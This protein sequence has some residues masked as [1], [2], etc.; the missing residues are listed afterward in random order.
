MVK[1]LP[2][3]AGGERDVDLIL[4][5]GRFPRGG[6]GNPHQYSSGKSHGQ[7]S[8]AGYSPWGHKELDTTEQPSA[9]PLWRTGWRFLNKLKIELPYDPA[10]PLLD[11]HLEKN[12]IRKDT[13]TSVF[14]E[15]RSYNNQD[16]EEPKCP[17]TDRWIKKM[18]EIYTME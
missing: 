14:T 8:L 4:G 11:I 17:P 2:A 9:Q 18:W 12:M 10:A 5:S 6:R 16:M 1:N 3:S 13:C 15:A 7:R